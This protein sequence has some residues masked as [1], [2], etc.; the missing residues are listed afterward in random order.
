MAN[1]AAVGGNVRYPSLQAIGDLFRASINDTMNSTTGTGT[2][3]GNAQGLIMGNNNPDLITFMDEAIPEIFS[4]LRNVGDPELIL[5][6]YILTGLPAL[7]VQDPTVQVA[8]S[9]A[10]FFDGY[11]WHADW[12][13]PIG[14]SKLL[15][16][17]ERQSG[18]GNSFQPMRNAPFGIGGGY[19]GDWMGQYE[20][21][22]GMLWMPGAVQSVDLRIRCRIGYPSSGFSP[23][24]NFST[25]YVPILDC[26]NAIVSKMRIQYAMRFAPELYQ[27]CVAE[28]TRLMGKLK[29][30]VVRGMQAQE[31]QREEFGADATADFAIAWAWL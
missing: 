28:E 21:R 5:D 15:A 6:N 9:Y 4:D 3:T 13:L 27:T 31:N 23:D 25:T 24:L 16:V 20:M 18:T 8:L 30:E 7:T 10:G 12:T 14:L 11:Q 29:L 1:A 22:E 26:K 2:G 19:Q 17:W